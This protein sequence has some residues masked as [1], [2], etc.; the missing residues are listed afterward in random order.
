MKLSGRYSARFW[1][2]KLRVSARTLK[3]YYQSV[4]KRAREKVAALTAKWAPLPKYAQKYP[5]TLLA[6][7]LGVSRGTA[8]NYLNLE[9]VPKHLLTA[10]RSLK[11]IKPPTKK[12]IKQV[13][14]TAPEVLAQNANVSKK[15]ASRWIKAGEIPLEKA[16]FLFVRTDETPEIEFKRP[17]VSLKESRHWVFYRF[18][19]ELNAELTDDFVLQLDSYLSGF[20][21]K[22]ARPKQS[23]MYQ[24]GMLVNAELADDDMYLMNY[25]VVKF[26]VDSDDYEVEVFSSLEKTW[27][28]SLSYLNNQLDDWVRR[29]GTVLELY[30]YHRHRKEDIS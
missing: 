21:R 18:T 3:R 19:W 20:A 14:E 17:K 15:E 24:F 23:S 8:K 5:S 7:R 12:L 6:Q 13:L 26:Q 27:E 22:Y 9:A 16:Q 28:E 30:M 29:S 2:A 25:E 4:P 10:V 11:E 1:R